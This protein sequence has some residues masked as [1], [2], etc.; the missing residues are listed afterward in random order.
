MNRIIAR[1]ILASSIMLAACPASYAADGAICFS[2][3]LTHTQTQSTSSPD[4]NTTYPQITNN[5]RFTC[6]SAVSYTMGQLMQMGW[7]VDSMSPVSLSLSSVTTSTT[8]T[9][10]NKSRWQ[11]AVRKP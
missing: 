7:V 6:R 1:G 9:I 2:E 10:T 4:A 8:I 11:L 5:T 3:T